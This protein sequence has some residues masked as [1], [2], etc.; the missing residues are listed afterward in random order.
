MGRPK[1]LTKELK[2]EIC[3]RVIDGET[4]RQIAAEA[5]MPDARTIYRALAAEDEEE[6][7]QQYARA[8]EFQLYRMEDELLEIA[9]AADGESVQADRLRIDTRKWIM[10]KRAP[11]KYGERVTQE[12]EIDSKAVMGVVHIRSSR[13]GQEPT[14]DDCQ[15]MPRP[16]FTERVR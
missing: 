16:A 6:F 14:A 12:H 15:E 3:A 7:R 9:D 13:K 1:V 2:D 10:S 4:I 8:K 11:K 5:H